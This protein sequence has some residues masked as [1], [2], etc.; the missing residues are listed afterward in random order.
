MVFKS[1]NKF[2]AVNSICP[3]MGAQLKLSNCKNY[4]SCPW[5]GLS[6]N[7]HDFKSN[8]KIYSKLKYWN[9]KVDI[10]NDSLLVEI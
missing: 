10:K 8:H 2:F 9:V 7:T 3:H 4:I 5:H 1:K 6:F